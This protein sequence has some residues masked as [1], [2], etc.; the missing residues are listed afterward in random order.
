M[1]EQLVCKRSYLAIFGSIMQDPSLLSD[2]D[3]PLDRSDFNTEPFYEILFVSMYNLFMQGCEHI[4]EFTIDSYLSQYQNQYNIFQNNKGLEYLTSARSMVD[5]GNYDYFYHRLKKYSLLRYYANKGYDTN[6]I[7]NA[8]LTN[9]SEVETEQIKF[10][11]YTEE[12]I[13]EQIENDLVLTP[14]MKYCTNTLTVDVQAGDKLSELVEE[15]C[16]TPDVGVPL[17]SSG[18]NTACRGMRL[19][20]FYLRSGTTGSSKSRQAIMDVCNI[21][22]PYHWNVKSKQWE[23]TGFECPALFISTEMS[24]DECQTIILATISGVNEE[25][26]LYGDY[27]AGE[28]E[29]V[30]QAIQYIQSSPLYICVCTDFSIS[31]IENIIKRYHNTYSVNYVFFD[32]LHSSLRLITEVGAKSSMRMQEYQLLSIFSTRLKALAEQ[33]NIFIMSSTQ[34][35]YEAME[36]KYKDQNCLQGSKQI[37]NKIDVGIISMRPTQSELKKI[38]NITK[39][40]VNCPQ[41][42]MMHWVYKVRRGKLTRII[43]FSHIDLGCMREKTVFVTDFDFNLIN[44]DFT[45]IECMDK[46]IEANSHIMKEE[47]F[48]QQNT[49]SEE[50]ETKTATK[51]DW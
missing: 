3:R 17:T 23:Y 14:K 32:Y 33:L 51:F 2:I 50:T 34:L 43:I 9:P 39:K 24:E 46:V 26:I 48:E 44:V 16:E 7:F 40:I 41:I 8:T 49:S 45:K 31:D 4:D 38:E 36:A 6:L 22:V 11:N 30:Q 35:N 28:Y 18:L 47:D 21:S 13:I 37:A 29:R 12:S 1:N 19:G 25:H 15:L 20:K 27:E 10:D 5:I 42:N